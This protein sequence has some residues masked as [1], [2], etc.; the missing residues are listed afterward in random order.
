MF[1]LDISKWKDG[2]NI[3]NLKNEG[4]VHLYLK[5]TE[6]R[7]YIDPCLN[8]FYSEA[9]RLKIPVGFY[10]F[11]SANQDIEGQ[12]VDFWNSVKDKPCQLRYCLDME[13]ELDYNNF[14]YRFVNKFKEVSGLGEDA[15]VIY[16][17]GYYARDN[18]NDDIKGK[19]PLWIAHY[20]VNPGQY[21]QTGFKIIAGHQY[22]ENESHQGMEFDANI[23]YPSIVIPGGNQLSET[24]PSNPKVIPGGNQKVRELQ[25]ICRQYGFNITI[26]GLWGPETEEAVKQLP[27][28]GLP[29][30]TP[31]LTKWVQLRVGVTV[32]GI[33]GQDTYNEVV[34]FQ[35][36]HNLVQDGIVGFNTLKEMALC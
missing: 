2:C 14:V 21:M 36:D 30:K 9:N 29:Y 27:L 10:H 31:A 18:F 17:S 4:L 1:S 34:K 13:R 8:K 7:N 35:R 15:I 23:F 5:A 6:G 28:A 19:Y 11:A 12:A 20:G 26:D 16:A 32:D 3:E 22:S 25:T 24:T 33:F